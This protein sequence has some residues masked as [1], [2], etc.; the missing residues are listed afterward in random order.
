MAV[1]EN[2]TFHITYYISKYLLHPNKW[3]T[4]VGKPRVPLT[5]L[6]NV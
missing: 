2:H 5:K 4:V 3:L 1:L 6:V